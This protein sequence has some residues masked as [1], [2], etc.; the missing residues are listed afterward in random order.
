MLSGALL[1]LSNVLLHMVLVS[2][3]SSETCTDSGTSAAVEPGAQAIIASVQGLRMPGE[4]GGCGGVDGSSAELVEAI[5]WALQ[6]INQDS[7]TI[8]GQSISQS[9]IPGVKIG[10][11]DTMA[12]MLH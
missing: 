11:A 1:V 10:N 6:R 3:L 5:R 2:G 9:Y 7:G 12:Y 4:D 8:N